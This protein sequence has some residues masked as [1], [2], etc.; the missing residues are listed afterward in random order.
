MRL[1]SRDMTCRLCGERSGWL[2]RTCS[3][4]EQVQHT[5]EEVRGSG[6]GE[7]LDALIATG[8]SRAQIEAFLGSDAGGGITVRDQIVADSTNQLMDA[9]GTRRE[10][11]A[12]DVSRIR[13]RGAWRELDK[14]PDGDSC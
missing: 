13:Q 8:A 4:C 7:I 1:L 12:A 2:R 6:L 5:Y 3:T 9:L 14:R 10:K 11:T